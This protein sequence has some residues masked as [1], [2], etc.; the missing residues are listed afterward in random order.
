MVKLGNAAVAHGAV[1]G[2]NGLPYLRGKTNDTSLA[3]SV[4]LEVT[5]A[6]G[7]KQTNKQKSFTKQVLQNMLRSRLPVSASSTIVWGG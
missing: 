1:F 5:D 4:L 2:P 6:W 3:L 7:Q